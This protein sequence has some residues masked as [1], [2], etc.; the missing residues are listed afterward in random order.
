MEPLLLLSVQVRFI[1]E[2]LSRLGYE[3]SYGVKCALRMSVRHDCPVPRSRSARDA[4]GERR[5]AATLDKPGDLMPVDA[6]GVDLRHR[7]GNAKSSQ[8]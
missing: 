7:L 8:L 4:K 1:T 3:H 5:R 2:Q 6:I